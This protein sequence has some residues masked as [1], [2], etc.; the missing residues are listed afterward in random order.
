MSLPLENLDNKTFYEI[1]NEALARLPIYAPDWTD[2]N[3]HDPGISFIELFAWLTE[4]QL[5][6]LNRIPEK[7]YKKFLKLLGILKLNPPKPAK[8]DVTFTPFIQQQVLIPAETKIAAKNPVTE[9]NIIFET[10]EAI[11]ATNSRLEKVF[12]RLCLFNWDDVPGVDSEK[13]LRFFRYDLKKE[14]A[15]NCVINKKGD[16][17]KIFKDKNFAIIKPEQTTPNLILEFSDEPKKKY[18][19]T[20]EKEKN[21]TKI[22]SWFI[23]RTDMNNRENTFYYAFR[24]KPEIGDELYLGFTENLKIDNPGD[25]DQICLTVY[26]DDSHLSQ[27]DTGAENGCRIF[28]SAKL[29]WEYYYSSHT[30][31]LPWYEFEIRDETLNFMK[32]GKIFFSIERNML[33]TSINGHSAYWLRCKIEED[34]YENPPRIDQILLNTISAIQRNSIYDNKYSGNGLA[35]FCIDLDMIAILEIIRKERNGSIEEGLKVNDS[36]WSEVDDFDASTPE[37]RHYSLDLSGN[38]ICFGDGING[39]IP[40]KGKENISVSYRSGGGILGNVP[41]LSIKRVLGNLASEVSVINYKSATG[42][43]EAE[44]LEQA[45]QRARKDMRTTYRAVTT[46]DYENLAYSAPGVK[47]ARARA[48]PRYHPTHIEEVPGVVTVVVVPESCYDMPVPSS[49]FL[50]TVYRHLDKHRI[51]T[52]ELF[53]IP[54]EYVN[55]VVEA[56][57]Y[58]KPQVLTGSVEKAIKDNLKKFLNPITG[59]PDGSGWPFGRSVYKSEIYELID[60]VNG[61]DYIDTLKLAQGNDIPQA[62]DIAIPLSCLVISGEHTIT[63]KEGLSFSK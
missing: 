51:L 21:E 59:G 55:I 32:C 36:E 45:K 12:S 4:I 16:I 27:N 10:E 39:S 42:G 17:I 52:A 57:V 33:Q 31:K 7:N 30:E 25:N 41:P 47:V 38:R 58:I 56:T 8:V 35:S 53:V 44:T 1:V 50:K 61:V 63:A 3:L 43:E 15:E 13:L 14:W 24:Y 9:E 62:S 2:H 49:G 40:P 29:K 18:V 5:Y 34:G 6:R 26:L 54:T 23:D 60:N 48:I 11:I 46:E 19:L 22:Y 28:P 20:V 37:D